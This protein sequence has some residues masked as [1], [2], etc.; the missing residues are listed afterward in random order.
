MFLK[1]LFK[2]K[3][4]TK[5]DNQIIHKSDSSHSEKTLTPLQ[6]ERV[7]ARKGE[8]GEYKIDIQ[9]SQLPKEYRYLSDLLVK[10]TK[11]SS[12]F[13][14]I[15]HIV[16]TPYGL[17]V[18]ET[19]NYQGT[20]YASSD[21]KT[22]LVNGKFK[23]MNP[24]MQ[25]YGHIES[26]KNVIDSSYHKHFIS[27]VSFT[28]RCTF[29]IEE[30]LRKIKSDELVIYDVELSEFINRKIAVLK[31]QYSKPLLSIEDI[32]KIYNTL[33]KANILDETLRIQHVERIQKRKNENKE[34]NVGRCAICQ[35]PVSDKV[36]S[37][38]LSTKKF[39]GEIYCYDHQK[40]INS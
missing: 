25:N 5:T 29:K 26:I 19:K 40:N 12:G 2:K 1:S 4:T 9:L 6:Q 34:A 36:K 31:L 33:S 7:A 27:I 23:M 21:K 17:F 20:I 15:D 39:Q 38:C 32:E 35:K 8:I 18:I 22:W 28:K 3:D 37:Y 11:S 16:I 10:N 30:S 13:S 14:Q 24:L